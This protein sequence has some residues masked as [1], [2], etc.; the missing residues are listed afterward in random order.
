M[1]LYTFWQN[2]LGDAK[3]YHAD[4]EVIDVTKEFL[5][6]FCSYD[7]ESG[8]QEWDT[9]QNSGVCTEYEVS[10]NVCQLIGEIVE[11]NSDGGNM[12]DNSEVCNFMQYM[13]EVVLED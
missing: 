4:N 8:D 2:M 3:L 11:I 6:N 9:F 7:K 13:N 12:Y 1:L 5:F 10:P